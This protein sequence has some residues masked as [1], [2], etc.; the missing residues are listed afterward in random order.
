MVAAY[1]YTHEDEDYGTVDVREEHDE[2]VDGI[3]KVCPNC[4]TVLMEQEKPI[5]ED[6]S[7]T[8]K[9]EFDPDDDDI[10]L[11]DYLNND[12]L[13]CPTC[14][15]D[16]DPELKEDKIVVTRITGVT[17][18]PKSRQC[19]IVEGGL[20]VR[21]PNWARDQKDCP[22]VGYD[23]ETH[24]S[25][26]FEEFPEFADEME[27][28]G[29]AITD[30]DG[31]QLYERW[32]RLNPQYRGDDSL[33]TPTLR[34]RWIR[35]STFW[36]VKDDDMR[37]RLCKK[38][39]DG[40]YI[41]FI[42]EQFVAAYNENLDDHWT[43]LFNPM[44]NYVTYDAIGTLV[45]AVQ[46]IT[47]NLISL[48]NQCIEHSVPTTFFNP[49]FLNSEQY[50]NTEIA[51][52]ALYPTKTVGENRNISDGFHTIQ[53]ATVSPELAPFG[54][55]INSLGQFVSGALP[56]IYGGS[57]G[58]SSRTASQ[59]AMQR[60]GAQ[61]R[62]S[63]L[64]GRNVNFFWRKLWSKVIPAYMKNMLE[65]ERIVKS[66]GIDSFEQT[67]IKKAQMDGKIGNYELEAPEGLP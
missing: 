21:V 62:L 42:N 28:L 30:T 3:Q 59:Y 33:N 49:K 66:V 36:C 56:Q 67:I 12:K 52:G 58:G 46:E 50:R 39:P 9:D 31:N 14:L 45:T 24:Y 55:R 64:T 4:G 11:H 48:E 19:I 26:L 40:A 13:L 38:F 16:I 5:S 65:D 8:E 37:K 63:S 17:R 1:N 51:P 2:M 61:V 34:K 54:E 29:R 23:R 53:A 47:V 43:I 57:S 32:G 27:E 22:Y 25:N 35:K 44:S 41:C 15:V 7:E 18:Q 10:K 60:N 6:L 20:Y